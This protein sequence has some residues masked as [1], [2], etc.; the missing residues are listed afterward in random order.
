MAT[1]NEKGLIDLA[2]AETEKESDA[3]VGCFS[4]LHPSYH[5]MS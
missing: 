2:F 1:V 4:C 5:N 3:P